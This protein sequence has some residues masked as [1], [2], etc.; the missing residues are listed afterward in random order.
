M[1]LAI[2]LNDIVYEKYGLE[3]ED[4]MKNVGDNVIMTNV[5]V[6]EIFKNMELSIIQLMQDIGIIPEQIGQYMANQA[7]QTSNPMQQQQNTQQPPYG[8]MPGTNPL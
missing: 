4:F 1:L 6:A 7:L 3:E 2:S 8:M 5:E